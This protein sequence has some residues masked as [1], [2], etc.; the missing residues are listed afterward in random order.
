[1]SKGRNKNSKKFKNCFISCL[2]LLYYIYNIYE[3]V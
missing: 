1:M 3:V 2:K